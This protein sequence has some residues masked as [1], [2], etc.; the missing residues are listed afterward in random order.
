M[1]VSSYDV[2][3]ERLDG[4]T[5][6]IYVSQR[7]IQPAQ[8]LASRFAQA[9]TFLTSLL[10][11]KPDI[12]LAVLSKHD[13]AR[14]APIP[15]FGITHYDYPH[16]M[17]V[18]AAQPST[19]WQPLI[20]RVKEIS[21]ALLHD[22]RTVYGQPDG[23]IDLT[24]NVEL[25]MF[26]DLGHAFH[27]AVPYWFPRRWLMEYFADLCAYS[28]VAMNEPDQVPALMRLYHTLHAVEAHHFS[29]R[30]LAEFEAH[31]DKNDWS[32]ENYLWYHGVLFTKA[33]QAFERAGVQALQQLW[34][35]FVGANV[36]QVSDTKLLNLLFQAQPELARMV[37][38]WAH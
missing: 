6:P 8:N 25:W 10:P 28:Y 9:Y 15:T 23:E 4:F 22:L 26:H 34:Q 33:Q 31:Y 37:E 3:L 30:T 13:W 27:L 11:V 16:R 29:Y 1:T 38:A 19:F 24:P 14:C 21:P 18:T 12:S 35:S 17:V 20:E 7:L 32:F 36:E 2:G 5:I